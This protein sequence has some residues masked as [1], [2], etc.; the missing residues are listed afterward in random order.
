MNW[1][2]GKKIAGIALGAGLGF[3]IVGGFG[4]RTSS[5]VTSA[6]DEAHKIS[7]LIRTHQ[8]ADMA[9]DAT[10]GD[11]LLA[12]L[13]DAKAAETAFREHR[14][15]LDEEFSAGHELSTME[16]TKDAWSA[17][18]PA[19]EK[20][21]AT[22][23]KVI[24]A[25]AAGEN[26][27][28]YKAEFAEA[29]DALAV[30]LGELTDTLAKERVH[31]EERVQSTLATQRTML[32]LVP[33]IVLALLAFMVRS[34]TRRITQP[35]GEVVGAL[36]KLAEGDLSADVQVTGSDEIGQLAESV[37]KAIGQLRETVGS[38][39][40]HVAGLAAAAE[41]LS[42][43]STQLGAGAEESSSQATSVS[44]GAEQVDHSV[45]SVAAAV[46][47]FSMS[48]REIDAACRQASVAAGESATAASEAQTT[49]SSLSHSTAEVGNIART[50]GNIAEQTKLLA[51]NATIEAARAGEAGKGFAVVANEVKD[52]A[53]ETANA[54]EQIE[55]SLLRIAADASGA[56]DVIGR[57][58][59][60]VQEN[61]SRFERITGAVAEQT[62]AA[63][64][65]ARNTA[66]AATTAGAIAESVSGV[67][68]A[69]ASTSDGASSCQRAATDLARMADEL[70][71]LTNGF[72]L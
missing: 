47:E 28:Q 4:L 70:R 58:A 49:V 50:I 72:T 20:Y 31:S 53:R 11:A 44:A 48:I 57:I 13:G 51:L 38:I 6:V 12:L 8:D 14:Q 65:I 43:V 9:H 63:S 18:K 33:V 60:A 62:D 45:Q 35:L 27:A 55:Q 34:V 29:Y 37:R 52:L 42:A 2:V 39:Q 40:G 17:A 1:T 5:S 66:E 69:A 46:E 3:V 59:E 19:V 25:A 24:A 21:L 64:E 54:T 22:V 67:A 16:S 71:R 10:R 30:T 23:E 7:E 68:Y 26:A 61:R 36:E 32:V 41:E 15:V 56:V